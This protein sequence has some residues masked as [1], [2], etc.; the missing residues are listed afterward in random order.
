MLSNLMTV[1]KSVSSD[2]PRG[3]VN[4]PPAAN[5]GRTSVKSWLDPSICRISNL[6]LT[7]LRFD[8]TPISASEQ[9]D[10]DLSHSTET[11][12]C[13]NYTNSSDDNNNRF[14]VNIACSAFT[15]CNLNSPFAPDITPTKI[16]PCP[17]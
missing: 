9:D 5:S 12:A 1:P 14:Q 17:F 3:S 7:S 15:V 13:K 10:G 2:S 8:K 11:V 4:R 16:M 6:K